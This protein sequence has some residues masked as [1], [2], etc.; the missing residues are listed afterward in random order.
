MKVKDYFYS[1]EIFDVVPSDNEGILKTLNIPA[2]LSKYYNS[3]NYI[4]HTNNKKGLKEIIYSLIQK[5]NLKYK[6]N[7]IQKFFQGNKIVDCGCGNGIFLEFMKNK[8]YQI[9][10]FEPSST[11]KIETE[12]R[13]KIKLASNFDEINKVDVITLWHVLEHIPNPD[14]ILKELKNKL[15]DDGILIIALPNHESYDAKIYGE[16]WA[17]YDVPRHVFHYSKDGAINYFSKFF[18]VKTTAPLLFDSYYISLLSGN[19]KQN[20][21]SFLSALKNGF[22]SNQKAK[23]DG[24]YSSVVYILTKI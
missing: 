16:F 1:Q 17:A 21:F 14:E 20:S 3:E 15:N 22:L 6:F 13:L 18:K 2:D 24:N 8:G 11:G 10:G 12:K 23:N 5:Q 9:Q 19:Y 4:S 7:L